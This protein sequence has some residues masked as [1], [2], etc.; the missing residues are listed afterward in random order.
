MN[1]SNHRYETSDLNLSAFLKVQGLDVISVTSNG[2]GRATFVFN[3]GAN[4][5]KL[6]TQFFN[7]ESR[8]E[9]LGYVG[10]MRSLKAYAA[11]MKQNEQRGSHGKRINTHSTG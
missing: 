7:Q 5:E 2:H 1:S 6:V 10:A 3:D 11:E 9:P 4:R 8:V